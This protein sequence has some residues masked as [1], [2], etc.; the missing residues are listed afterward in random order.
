MNYISP[1]GDTY[2]EHYPSPSGFELAG[3]DKSFWYEFD[4]YGSD[5]T[6]LISIYDSE[7]FGKKGE[8]PI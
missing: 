1:T 3:Y 8:F 2:K 4:A 6:N 7:P 5:P